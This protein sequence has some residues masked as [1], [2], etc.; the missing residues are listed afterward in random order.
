MA[1]GE[2]VE[3]LHAMLRCLDVIERQRKGRL[4]KP[5]DKPPN[6][7]NSRRV[8]HEW[9]HNPDCHCSPVRETLSDRARAVVQI[10]DGGLNASSR[11]GSHYSRIVH[12]PRDGWGRHACRFSDVSDGYSACS[13]TGVKHR[14]CKRFLKPLPRYAIES[15]VSTPISGFRHG[16]RRGC[17]V[18]IEEPPHG[19]INLSYPPALHVNAAHALREDMGRSRRPF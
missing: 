9:N 6:A 5:V 13:G 17:R 3:M 15:L 14:Q 4:A 1:S 7:L 12:N 2:Y 10:L 8:R 11:L 19:H 18:S 16:Y